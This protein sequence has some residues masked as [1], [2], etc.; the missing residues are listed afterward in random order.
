MVNN[1]EEVL[2]LYLWLDCNQ[3]LKIL[4][5]DLVEEMCVGER[6]GS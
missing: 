3:V 1:S 6:S 2:G 4:K 5:L